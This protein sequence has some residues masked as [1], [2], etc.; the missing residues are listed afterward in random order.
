VLVFDANDRCLRRQR[1]FRKGT[2]RSRA[3]QTNRCGNFRGSSIRHRH[4][5]PPGPRSRQAFG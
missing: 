5:A 1:S 3:I 2:W 4:Y